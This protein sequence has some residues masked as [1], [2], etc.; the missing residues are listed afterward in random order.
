MG[1][2]M[3]VQLRIGY[4]S[5]EFGEPDPPPTMG[6]TVGVFVPG[7]QPSEAPTG[8]VTRRPPPDEAGLQV[9]FVNEDFEPIIPGSAINRGQAIPLA[10]PTGKTPLLVEIPP[11]LCLNLTQ[12]PKFYVQVLGLEPHVEYNVDIRRNLDPLN[13]PV[14][15]LQP[16]VPPRGPALDPADGQPSIPRFRGVGALYGQQLLGGP[17]DRAPIAL[18]EFRDASPKNSDA[19]VGFEMRVGIERTG[20][21]NVESDATTFQITIVDHDSHQVAAGPIDVHPENNRPCYF[22]V[23]ATAI[24]GG[25]FD[26]YIRNLSRGQFASL[27]DAASLS[28]VI[29]EES[30]DLN[31]LKSLWILWMLSIL[32]VT[33]AL[34]CSTFL[35]WPI[36]VML[37]LLLLLGHWGVI[38]LGD[39]LAPGIGNRVAND[40]FGSAN[41]QA[42][43]AK[44]VSTTVEALSK[45]LTEL[46]D[47]LPDI[48]R[49]SAIDQIERGATIPI[50]DLTAPLSVLL[51][52]GLPLTVLS[53]VIFRNKEVAP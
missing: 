13:N 49:F 32:V 42:S 51:L 18:Y 39:A 41:G 46:S 29:S 24:K 3:A 5:T 2:P 47:L 1:R 31:L 11:D 25:N 34:F 20:E 17:A 21:S 50:T 30:F 43:K 36:A 6:L 14:C 48:T 53:Y 23:P 37:T 52:F 22:S 26:L 12:S 16:G 44:V 19:Q 10:D 15:I 9:T 35:S 45:V 4:R 27:R 33:I 28:M 8:S 7:T 40:I 38:Q